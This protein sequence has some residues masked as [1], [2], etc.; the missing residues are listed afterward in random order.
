MGKGIQINPSFY[1]KID[2][3][4]AED[5]VNKL[6]QGSMVRLGTDAANR[7]PVKTGNLRNTMTT[8]IEQSR[9]SG[10]KGSWDLIQETDYTI[11]QE[12]M[13]PRH[14]NFIRDSVDVEENRFNDVLTKRFKNRENT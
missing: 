10:I 11:I 5:D 4:E 2:D 3:V 6:S 13:N 9:S 7:A 12:K 14:P 1:K 8:G